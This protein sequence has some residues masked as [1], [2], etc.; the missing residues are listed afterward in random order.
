MLK[1]EG[2][3]VIKFLLKSTKRSELYIIGDAKIINGKIKH[4]I[5]VWYR[6]EMPEMMFL[7]LK[8]D[9]ERTTVVPTAEKKAINLERAWWQH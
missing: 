4:I 1:L 2:V 3:Y 5:G 6:N 9:D 7:I 8:K